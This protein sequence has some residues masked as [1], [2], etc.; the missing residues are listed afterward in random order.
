MH[1][2]IQCA[3]VLQPAPYADILKWLQLA[4]DA[5]SKG[6]TN[7]K[8]ATITVRFV[9]SK[10]SQLL[11]KQ[12]RNKNYATNVLTF[13]YS[14]APLHADLV[15]CTPVLRRES[16]Q[17][18]KQLTDHLAHLLM[19]GALHAM[20]FNHE[21]NAEANVMEALEISLLKRLKVA[22]PYG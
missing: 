13:T 2:T 1:L 16:K 15:L 12:Y 22:N 14:V 7:T 8:Q 5:V 9:G 18:G 3:K 20:G 4:I 6:S 10:E 21:T 19:H 17:Q 11:N